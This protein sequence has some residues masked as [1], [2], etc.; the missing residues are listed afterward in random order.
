MGG[1]PLT[2]DHDPFRGV[3]PKM[4]QDSLKMT[5]VERFFCAIESSNNVARIVEAARRTARRTF[6]PLVILDALH[7]HNVQYIV[8]G[9][10]AGSIHGSDSCTHDL[11][12]C[13]RRDRENVD[14]LARALR[15]VDARTTIGS[16]EEDRCSFETDGGRIHCLAIPAGT[17]GYDDLF[18]SSWTLEVGGSIVRVCSLD[19]LIRM[20]TA[21]GRLKDRIMLEQLYVLKLLT[22]HRE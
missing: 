22:D 11:D 20:K 19:D 7:R 5:A 10:L 2:W 13:H 4:M 14:A 16:L 6:E 18:V 9:G 3:D 21:A 12:I 17:N 8:I 15:D 1:A